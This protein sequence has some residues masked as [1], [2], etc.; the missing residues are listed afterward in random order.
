MG[1]IGSLR[2]DDTP[3][4]GQ[5]ERGITS[6]WAYDE[7][8][9]LRALIEATLPWTIY[10]PLFNTPKAHINWNALIN[11]ADYVYATEK[12]S[13][14]AQNDEISWD[15]VLGAG[16][17]SI[18]LIHRQ[19]VNRGIYSI[20]LGS[21]EKGTIDGYL[22]TVGANIISSVDGIIIPTTGKKE[23]KIKMAT[24]NPSATN[25]LGSIHSVALRRTS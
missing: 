11:S 16:T 24:K 5:T 14:G 20:Q 18:E 4:D 12:A 22:A 21:V 7:D 9:T 8:V 2:L 25:Y 13:S 19:Y 1:E 3:V 23:L 10:I 17:W 6:N 15:V